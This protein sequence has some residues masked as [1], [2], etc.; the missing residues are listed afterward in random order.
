MNWASGT[1]FLQEG[2]GLPALPESCLC[3]Y[4]QLPE[5]FLNPGSAE[6]CAGALGRV[7][8][9]NVSP[10]CYM[11]LHPGHETVCP[12]APGLTIDGDCRCGLSGCLALSPFSDQNHGDPSP[13]LTSPRCDFLWV[14]SVPLWLGKAVLPGWCPG[15]R[16]GLER[17]EWGSS[18]LNPGLS[19]P[20]L[21]FASPP[22][23]TPVSIAA[24]GLVQR[25]QVSGDGELR[26]P[27]Q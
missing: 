11:G 10:S 19:K 3:P 1:L 21:C 15:T 27:E 8:C 24:Q 16:R 12:C 9:E 7:S 5:E 14:I 23:P 18:E 6:R 25:V 4:T 2:L 20:T 22:P 13:P 17:R 26:S